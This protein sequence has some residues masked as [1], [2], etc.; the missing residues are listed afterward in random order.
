M[1]SLALD[2]R[3]SLSCYHARRAWDSKLCLHDHASP[4]THIHC[5]EGDIRDPHARRAVALMDRA[6]LEDK[7][8]KLMEENQVRPSLQEFSQAFTLFDH[9]CTLQ[10]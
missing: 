3:L 4:H 5:T 8:L 9:L 1:F 2:P 10:V 6:D 7:Q